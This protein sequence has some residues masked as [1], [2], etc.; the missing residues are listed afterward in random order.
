MIAIFGNP[1]LF[2]NLLNMKIGIAIN[3]DLKEKT[4][5]SEYV[6][7]LLDYLPQVDG[8]KNHQ[9]F[10]YSRDFLSEKYNQKILRWPFKFAWTQIRLSLEMLKNKPE[11]L[12]VPSHAFPFFCPRL[13]VA[14]QGIEYERVPDCYSWWQRKKLRFLTKRNTKRAEKIIVPSECTK[15]DLIEIYKINPKKIFVVPHGIENQK[16]KTRNQNDNLKF[17]NKYILYLGSGHKRKN[18]CGLKKAFE[19]LKQKYKISH[20]LILA[21][22]DKKIDEK[23]KWDLLRGADVFVFPSFYE[24]FGFPVL[25][26][27]SVGAP[28]VASN[29]SSLSEILNNSA[30]LINPCDS[31]EI[32]RDV[33]KVLT[34]KNLRENLI[35][36]GQENAKS[37]SWQGC[38]E[39]TLKTIIL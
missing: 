7:R 24:G 21:G 20:E 15:K 25:E 6:R 17:K 22:V 9:F 10:I 1:N 2:A 31:E 26:A 18:I 33:Y 14:V 4:G 34:D 29:V 13:V 37:F 3:L 28:V 35:K 27:Q 11:I 5:I 38:A 23:E 8:F 30:L 12:F 32:A 19:I 39:K 16:S 36:K